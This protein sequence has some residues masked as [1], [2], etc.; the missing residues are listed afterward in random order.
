MTSVAS[1]RPNLYVEHRI[2]HRFR[3]CAVFL[4]TLLS[5]ALA[6]A[7]TVNIVFAYGSEKDDWLKA[8]TPAFNADPRQQVDG[9]QIHVILEPMGSGE[10]IEALRTGNLKPHLVSPAS[11]VFL[12]LADPGLLDKT[13]SL[14]TSPVVIAV[15]EDKA[16]ALAQKWPGRRIGWSDI[17]ELAK[18]TGG[19]ADFGHP[20]WGRFKFGHTHP[21]HSNSG[22]IA[23]VAQAYAAAHKTAGLSVDDVNTADTAKLM[24]GIGRS[25][26]Y[27]G[28]STGFFGKRMSEKPDLLDAAVLYE[29][30]VVL[31]NRD[32]KSGVP[33]LVAI[34][35]SDGTFMSDHPVGIVTKS[36]VKDP[37][38]QA[39]QKYID[40]L[41]EEPQQKKAL[42]Y[43]FRP[44]NAAVAVSAPVDA[45]NGVDPAQ[46][47][48]LLEVPSAEVLRACQKAWRGA[49]KPANVVLAIDISFSMKG[50]KINE[51]IGGGQELVDLLGDRDKLSILAFNSYL[52]W[53]QTDVPVGAAGN[54]EKIKASLAEMK[55]NWQT[56]L[57]DAVDASLDHLAANA[58][59]ED[60]GAIS[61]L[62]VLSD[63]KDY[64][65]TNP[66]HRTTLDDVVKTIQEKNKD[67]Q[68]AIFTIG[69]GVR[70]ADG[71][72]DKSDLDEP[73]LKKI[74]ESS[75][76]S[77][78]E[79]SPE[80]L[81][82]VLEKLS[83]FFSSQEP[84]P[85]PQ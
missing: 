43:G 73:A 6:R 74:A 30:M 56:K 34:Y 65:S 4:L 85:L 16:N 38:K 84:A 19:W 72:I 51:A 83:A 17:F 54:R 52:K 71:Q 58:E 79:S 70:T 21:E 39:A 44:G 40:W 23:V 75:G 33:K 63:G 36:W 8:I 12:K 80:K 15:W 78:Q 24:A 11:Q 28:S 13:T 26:V 81:H 31:H 64:D 20:E 47:E 50:Q 69:Y 48:R 2:P 27:Y 46:P 59:G 35:P 62:I 68:I 25:V 82:E 57:Y 67:R 10:L 7:E 42:E 66:P 3:L 32:R 55:P 53:I 49:K 14:V 61:C 1:A 29:N 45:D 37:E 41:L 22:L 5:P 9:A 76:G 18:G 77:Y 60:Q